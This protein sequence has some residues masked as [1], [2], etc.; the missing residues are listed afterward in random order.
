MP[1]PISIGDAVIINY[2]D[3]PQSSLVAI[4][5][6]V[7][8]TRVDA[9]YLAA[10]RKGRTCYSKPENVT[11]LCDFGVHLTLAGD[12]YYCEAAGISRATYADGT[13][14]PWQDR[15]VNR[16][17]MDAQAFEIFRNAR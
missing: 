11:R 4:V 3:D 15:T 10:I 13:R 5:T 2:A 12:V 17:E 6:E 8:D 7:S 9:R 1:K 16:W 14:R